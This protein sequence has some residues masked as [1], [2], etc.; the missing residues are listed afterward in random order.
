MSGH[1]RAWTVPVVVLVL[2][3]GFALGV[4]SW[5]GGG[6]AAGSRSGGVVLRVVDE[7]G[8]RIPQAE[9]FVLAR[10]DAPPSSAGTWSVKEASLTLPPGVRPEAVAVQARGFRSDVIENLVEDRTIVLRRGIRVRLVVAGTAVV[11]EDPWRIVFQVNPAPLDEGALS[12]DQREKLV[13]LI[14]TVIPPSDEAL[15]L[16]AGTFG[17]A[18]G[19]SVAADGIRMPIPGRYT[20]R[21]GLLDTSIGAWFSLSKGARVCI[22]V[23]DETRV[24][25]FEI[26]VRSEEWARTRKG[27]EEHIR[28]MRSGEGR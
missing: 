24:Q 1:A 8:R 11:V 28:R 23:A 27:L 7:D 10:P 15:M 4:L 9:V 25:V 18:V 22:V 5:T 3:A 26:P 20:V 2:A 19:A 14:D 21:W 16:P 12:P 13:D 17:F 6:D